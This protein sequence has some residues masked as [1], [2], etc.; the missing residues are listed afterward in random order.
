MCYQVNERQN[1]RARRVRDVLS[2]WVHLES[3]SDRAFNLKHL[4]ALEF[5]LKTVTV[6]QWHHLFTVQCGTQIIMDK[7]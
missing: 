2:S 6:E 3:Q 1:A 7:I 4:L 5:H